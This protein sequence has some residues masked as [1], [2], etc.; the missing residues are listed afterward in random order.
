MIPS[1]GLDF[2][3]TNTVAT[4]IGG[5]GEVDAVHFEHNGEAFDAFRSVLCFSEGENS[6]QRTRI[7]AGPWAI[8]RFVELAGDCR[9][10]QSFKTFA[11]SPLFTDTLIYNKRLKFE[12]LLA[13]FLRQVRGHAGIEFPKRVVI[14]RPVSF[15]GASPDE[16]LARTRYE[17]ALRLMGFEE[18]HHVYEPVAAA[19]FFAQRLTS[20]A[21]ILVA[22]FGGGTSD[23]SVVKFSVGA[24]GLDYKPLAHTGVGVAGDAFDF[25]I[26][27]NVVAPA[28]GKGSEFMSWGKALPVPLSY[29]Q[30]FSRWNELSMMRSS[31]DYREL[32]ELVRDSLDPKRI[33]AF[34]AFLDADAGYAMYRAVSAAKMQLSQADAGALS[35]HV[36]GVD[37]EQ[38]IERGQ[39]EA[40]IAPELQEI[41]AC[42][43]RA[44]DQAGLNAAR[45][46]RVFLTGGSSFVPAVREMFE[47][48]FGAEKIE[49]G[50]QLVSIAYGLSLIGREP[51]I[52]RWV[53]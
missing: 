26:I 3:T 9:F 30:K 1:I 42:V 15:A 16:S 4:M 51:D 13:G 5:N 31:R 40:W 12:D 18:I 37:I 50:D 32:Q 25:R 11:A 47:A 2:G 23:F 17:A 33:E 48:Q 8:D 38:T 45:I 19:Y 49:T 27:D 20:D 39:F 52:S 44:L 43:D 6:G 41:Q 35:L 14:G 53:A 46:D 28:F 29:F 36:A 22:D 10:I 21:T 7:D 24:G 34:L